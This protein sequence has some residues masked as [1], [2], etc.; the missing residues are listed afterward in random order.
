[1][2]VIMTKSRENISVLTKSLTES[3]IPGIEGK[4]ETYEL[5]LPYTGPRIEI[6][7][8]KT[9]NKSAN[10]LLSLY[11][12]VETASACHNFLLLDLLS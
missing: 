11:S 2:S 7:T 12:Q 4:Y 5:W 8:T 3:T 1:M 6:G 10:H 9:R